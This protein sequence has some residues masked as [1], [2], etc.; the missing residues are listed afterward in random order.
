MSAD[1]SQF[2]LLSIEELRN[3]RRAL[4]GVIDRR[5][6]AVNRANQ[7]RREADDQLRLVLAEIERRK[8]K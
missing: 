3:K 8:T 5:W 7:E 2:P 6:H 4:R 1:P